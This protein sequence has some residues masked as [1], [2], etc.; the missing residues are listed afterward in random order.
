MLKFAAFSLLSFLPSCQG[1]KIA[2]QSYAS[3]EAFQQS[4]HRC[5]AE[6]LSDERLE[7]MNVRIAAVDD[8]DHLRGEVEE[9]SV[10]HAASVGGGIPVYWHTIVKTDGTGTLPANAIQDSIDVL[11]AAFKNKGIFYYA[12]GE[13]TVNDDWYDES[14]WS[15]EKDMKT[16]LRQGGNNALN[17]YSSSAGGYLGYAYFPDILTTSNAILDGVVILDESVPGGSAS[18]YDLGDTLVHEVG[19]WFGLYHTFERGCNGA[20]DEISDTPAEASPAYGCPAGRDTCSSP[21]SDPIYNFMDYS[22][23]SCM[24]HFTP[25]QFRRMMNGFKAYRL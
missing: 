11:N 13:V 17:V 24:D 2:G 7:A 6:T 10:L 1:F 4:G 20:G 14:T 21:G 16:A 18:P 25:K 3:L 19:H 23:D 15:S 5:G 8:H 12:G 22:D 9:A